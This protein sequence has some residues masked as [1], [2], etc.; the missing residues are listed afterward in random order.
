M[1]DEQIATE[2]AAYQILNSKIDFGTGTKSVQVKKLANDVEKILKGK[3]DAAKISQIKYNITRSASI[4]TNENQIADQLIANVNGQE[5]VN[6]LTQIN[7][8]S[9]SI[10][11]QAAA[12]EASL[13]GNMETFRLKK[14]WED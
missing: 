9:K 2:Q 7:I 10:A 1:M 13:T 12:V 5:Y 6:A 4:I 3:V 11:E 14:Y 8:G